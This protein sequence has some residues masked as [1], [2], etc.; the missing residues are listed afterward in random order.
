MRT[1]HVIKMLTTL[2]LVFKHRLERTFIM[3]GLKTLF[4]KIFTKEKII[5]YI[6]GGAIVAGSAAA[7]VK[8]EDVEKL[9]CKKYIEN[10]K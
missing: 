2:F 9:V 7:S 5:A 1:G 8:S 10:E 4:F 6:V 3:E